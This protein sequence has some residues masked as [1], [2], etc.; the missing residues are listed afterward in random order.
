ML[1]DYLSQVKDPRRAQGKSYLLKYVL[2]FTILAIL[3]GAKSYRDTARFMKRRREQLNRLF[4]L[5]WKKT[6]AKSQLRNIFCRLSVD[7][8][9]G[10][11]RQYSQNLSQLSVKMNRVGLDGK[12]LRGSFSGEKSQDMLQLLGA[13]CAECALILG[14]IDI[15]EK[16][17][18]IPTAQQLIAELELPAGTIYTADALHC[19][20]K[21]LRPRLKRKGNSLFN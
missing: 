8:V 19:Q 10:I 20:K 21:H 14:H 16:T 12:S 11:F 5:N 13:F 7:S 15:S 2:L 6:P 1:L 18:E 3:S 9:E 4:H 17:N